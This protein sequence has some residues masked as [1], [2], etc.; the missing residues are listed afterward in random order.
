[1][2]TT[3][4]SRAP[5]GATLA[6]VVTVV[7][8]A[9]DLTKAQCQDMASAVR[10]VARALGKPPESIPA[11]PAMLARRLAEVAPVS[12]GITDGRWSNVRS[13][14]GKALALTRPMLPGRHPE[15]LSSSWQALS[16]ALPTRAHAT[17]LSRLLHWLSARSIEPGGVTDADL[18]AFAEDLRS[19]SL[20]KKPE[21]TWREVA[22]LWNNA[23]RTVTGWPAI[24]IA[25]PNRRQTIQCRGLRSPPASR[26]MSSVTSTAS[27]AVT[28]LKMALDRCVPRRL[29]SG[30]ANCAASHRRWSFAAKIRRA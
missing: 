20:A 5:S 19:A 26:S 15:P 16:D 18:L 13:L 4:A 30:S 24:T 25:I 8:S 11:D 27:L 23:V 14:L 22:R 3:S 28:L 21:D 12:I 6:D 9:P 1:M 7:T 2:S 10:T 29:S 17:R